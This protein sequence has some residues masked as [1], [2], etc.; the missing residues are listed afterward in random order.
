MPRTKTQTPRPEAL[1]ER[2]PPSVEYRLF[3]IRVKSALLRVLATCH[4]SDDYELTDDERD[5]V[6][7]G[8]HDLSAEIGRELDAIRAAIGEAVLNGAPDVE[9]GAR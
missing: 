5:E 6:R 7:H 3:K 2:M 1:A 8:A 9:G 4:D